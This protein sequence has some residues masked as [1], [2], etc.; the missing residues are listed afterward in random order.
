[1]KGDVTDDARR[2]C[3]ELGETIAAGLAMGIF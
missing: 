3:F 1:V 2:R